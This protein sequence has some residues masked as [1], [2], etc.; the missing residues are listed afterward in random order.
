M[1]KS[2]FFKAIKNA[3]FSKTSREVLLFVFFLVLS[4]IFWLMLTL[5]D[6]Y[7]HEIAI[8]VRITN[9]PKDVVLTSEEIDTLKL[10]V[11][12]KGLVIFSYL[13]GDATPSLK[14]N[15]K[16]GDRGN[17]T[18]LISGAELQYLIDK[19]LRSSTR[20]SSIKPNHLLYYYNT[21]AHKRVPVRWRG[22][23]IPEQLYFI[24]HVDYSPDSV[25]IF[26]PEE[27]LDSIKVIYTETLNSVGFRDSLQL[28]CKLR[29]V[30]GVKIV[31]DNVHITFTTDL[32]TEESIDGIPVEGINMPA[33]K[34][35]RTFPAK[36]RVK[37]VSG[38]NVYRNLKVSD[39]RVV[40]DYNELKD[41]TS[42]KCNIYLQQMPQ[43]ISRVV[44]EPRQVDYLIE[45]TNV[46]PEQPLTPS[47]ER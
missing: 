22:R 19:R 4:G 26:A 6:T 46:N 12:D 44:I 10:T 14:I 1:K 45:E 39:F 31:P 37:F 9:I 2:N 20:V 33:G 16:L 13:Y 21:G 42:E 34:V 38:V 32:L 15:F 41:R 23:V 18:G 11:R 3:L 36:V 28:H 30:E 47:P 40:A 24:S 7:E 35:L 27:K 17:G 25:T 29:R 43:G 5:N 8:P